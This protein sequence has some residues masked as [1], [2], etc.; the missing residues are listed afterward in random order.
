[1]NLATLTRQSRADVFSNLVG[2][3]WAYLASG[4]RRGQMYDAYHRGSDYLAVH[5][6]GVVVSGGRL[7]VTRRTE[8][9]FEL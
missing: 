7:N 8:V 2:T 3:G 6:D 9:V 4:C 1:M 5:H